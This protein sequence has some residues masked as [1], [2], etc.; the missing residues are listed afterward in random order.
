MSLFSLMRMFT[1]RF[2][3]LG[4]IAVVLCLLGMLGGGPGCGACC[5]SSP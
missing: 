2:R 3:M 5:A 1:I 4:A